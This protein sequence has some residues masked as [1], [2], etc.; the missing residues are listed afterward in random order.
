MISRKILYGMHLKHL[1]KYKI[2]EPRVTFP[3]SP[4]A[5]RHVFISTGILKQEKKFM[6]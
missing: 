5:A 2:E 6:N 1:V 4:F 3:E